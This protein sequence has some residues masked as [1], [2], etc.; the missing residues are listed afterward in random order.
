MHEFKSQNARRKQHR[1]MCVL[2]QTSS[3]TDTPTDCITI[4]T[5]TRICIRITRRNSCKGQQ[6]RPT[7]KPACVNTV[8]SH[9]HS[10]MRY[11]SWP[12]QIKTQIEQKYLSSSLTIIPYLLR[13]HTT[14]EQSFI[15]QQSERFLRHVSHQQTQ[16]IGSFLTVGCDIKLKAA[17]STAGE[18]VPLR[19]AVCYHSKCLTGAA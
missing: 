14:R 12:Y 11:R 6:K 18:A 16:K 2:V 13:K 7:R 19:S 5:I 15:L 17:S 8:T 4:L 3:D 9:C 10:I 1:R